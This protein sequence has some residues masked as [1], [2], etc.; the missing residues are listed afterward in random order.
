VKAVGAPYNKLSRN[1]HFS[2]LAPRNISWTSQTP[3]NHQLPLPVIAEKGGLNTFA[4][5]ENH[6]ERRFGQFALKVTF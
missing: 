6:D 1:P 4:L 3:G 5:G 2:S